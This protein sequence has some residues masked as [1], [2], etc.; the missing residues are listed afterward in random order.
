[1]DERSGPHISIKAEAIFHIGDFPVTNT[2]LMASVV[3]VGFLLLAV[4]YTAQSQSE[5]KGGLFY[6]VTFGL[7]AL[8]NLFHSVFGERT[9]RYYG[10]LA[11]FFFY[12]LLH[13]WSG[14]LPGVGSVLF[15]VHEHGHAAMVPLLRGNTTDLNATIALAFITVFYAQYLGITHLGVWGYLSKFINLKSPMMFFVG[16]M[17]T[18]SEL[19]RLVSYSFRLFGNIFAGEVIIAIV[20]FLV[21]ILVSFPF[22]VFEIFVGFIQAIVF[23]MLSAVFFQLATEKAH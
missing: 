12:I 10:L 23:A 11:A 15:K 20:A 5:K 14:L 6:V 7:Q 16:L 8:Y 13:N 17:E 4:A 21:P 9:D 18:I 3:F 19:S 22:L 2:L 1:M